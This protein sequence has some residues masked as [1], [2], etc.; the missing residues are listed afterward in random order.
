MQDAK[1][2]NRMSAIL[3][4]I[5]KGEVVKEKTLICSDFQ[6]VDSPFNTPIIEDEP[7]DKDKYN[8]FFFFDPDNNEGGH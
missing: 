6:D 7:E 5:E 3:V 8:Y 4:D 1:L 2:H